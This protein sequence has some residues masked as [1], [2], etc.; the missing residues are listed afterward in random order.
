MGYF[1]HVKS[2]ELAKLKA[3]AV[4]EGADIHF[5]SQIK[6]PYLSF[7]LAVLYSPIHDMSQET[8]KKKVVREKNYRRQKRK[9][10]KNAI[11]S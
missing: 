4:D 7:I 5:L 3:I 1:D 8:Y 11:Q 10:K 6:E 2:E 9:E